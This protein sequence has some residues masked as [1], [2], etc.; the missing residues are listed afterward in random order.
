M[1]RYQVTYGG[2]QIKQHEYYGVVNE[3]GLPKFIR[4]PNR[5]AALE[6]LAKAFG[7]PKENGLPT[8]VTVQ[9]LG[10]MT[11]VEPTAGLEY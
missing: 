11:P 1:N 7:A 5:L 9:Y 8:V 2:Y 3:Q 6:L 4:A 10:V